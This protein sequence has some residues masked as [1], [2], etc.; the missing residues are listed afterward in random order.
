MLKSGRPLSVPFVHPCANCSS[1]TVIA[2]T[3]RA[4]RV[5]KN[6]RVYCSDACRAAFRA[7]RSSE[8]MARTNRQYASERMT[9]RNPMR[10][11]EIRK[12]VSCSLR[13]IG[14]QPKIRG[15]NGCGITHAQ[16]LMLSAL[17][18]G[19]T[20]EY[21]YPTRM[22]RGSGYPSHYKLDIA[23]PAIKAMVEVDGLSHSALDRRA[24]DQRKTRFMQ[25]RGWLV[26]R[27]TN[28]QVM[29]HLEACYQTVTS[30]ISKSP[31]H[32]TTTLAAS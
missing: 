23:N 13:A 10:R 27:F 9:T 12:K 6:M 19:W 22:G 29:E 24:Q 20:T 1:E 31:E 8:V 4:W 26:F 7:Q 28:R 32:T 3:Y 17:G 25:A 15:G 14:H 18:I 16:G 5:R 2:D 30:T 11:P 21:I